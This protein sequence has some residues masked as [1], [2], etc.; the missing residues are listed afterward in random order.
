MTTVRFIF[1]IS[2]LV[3][4]VPSCQEMNILSGEVEAFYEV[5]MVM[6][7]NY[8]FPVGG[9]PEIRLIR[10]ETSPAIQ[11]NNSVFRDSVLNNDVRI[12]IGNIRIKDGAGAY[13]IMEFEQWEYREGKWVTDSETEDTT[14]TAKTLDLVLLLDASRSLNDS[15]FKLLQTNAIGFVMRIFEESDSAR[16]AVAGF[17]DNITHS[18]FYEEK[19]IAQIMSFINQRLPRGGRTILYEAMDSS[20]TLLERFSQADGRALVTFTD[21]RN[22]KWTEERFSTSEHIRNRI[23]Q[24]ERNTT[25]FYSSF[26]IGFLGDDGIDETILNSLT[27]KDGLFAVAKTQSDAAFIFQRFASIVPA[28]YR[29]IY[30][31]NT[32]HTYGEPIRLKYTFRVWLL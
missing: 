30:T 2:I 24:L 28:I 14:I 13:R 11:T 23:K 32:S 8:H 27:T 15:N 17:S 16:I 6:R 26:I 5:N 21:G 1:A 18:K 7:L 31:R 20:L 29:F 9:N 19:D 22:N 3:F 25:V 12:E 4:T 10:E